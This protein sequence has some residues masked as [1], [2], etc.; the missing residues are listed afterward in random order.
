M[1]D[2][3]QNT[4]VSLNPE[5]TYEDDL[6]NSKYGAGKVKELIVYEKLFILFFFQLNIVQ[7]ADF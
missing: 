6:I 5:V 2:G 4:N 3:T 1:Y 7:V